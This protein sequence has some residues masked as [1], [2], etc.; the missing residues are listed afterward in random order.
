[1]RTLLKKLRNR[2]KDERGAALVEFAIVMPLLLVLIFGMVEAGWAFNSQL[3]ATHAARE[4]GRLAAVNA[5]PVNGGGNQSIK[6]IFETCDRI[7]ASADVSMRLTRTGS[8][9]GGELL[10]EVRHQYQPLVG[11]LPFFNGL[12]LHSEISMRLE[13]TA[14]WPNTGFVAC[15]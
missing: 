2:D 3:D 7:D 1:M 10:A 12:T 6:I 14:T 4:A 9:I 8:Q 13:Q 11:F 5:T 15:P